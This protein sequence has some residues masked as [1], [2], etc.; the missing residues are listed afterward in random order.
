M[1]G[2]P[3]ASLSSHG[4]ASSPAPPDLPLLSPFAVQ[5]LC[6]EA[7]DAAAADVLQRLLAAILQRS[8]RLRPTALAALDLV[9]EA[10]SAPAPAPAGQLTAERERE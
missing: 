6:D 5:T 2:A 3:P 9:Q 4:P 1:T 7:G 10:A 8:P